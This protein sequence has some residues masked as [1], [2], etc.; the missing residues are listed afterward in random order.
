[1]VKRTE[2]EL[3]VRVKTK[4]WKRSIVLPAHISDAEVMPD[5]DKPGERLLVTIVADLTGNIPK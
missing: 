3:E 5:V 2:L 4:W 1:M